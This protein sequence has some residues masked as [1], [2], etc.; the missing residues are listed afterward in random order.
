[1][2]RPAP[3]ATSL[4]LPYPTQ[5]SIPAYPPAGHR[6]PFLPSRKD[7]SKPVAP[8][9]AHQLPYHSKNICAMKIKLT[10]FL[11]ILK[12]TV[13]GQLDLNKLQPVDEH[14]IRCFVNARC[15]THG[16]STFTVE[17][18]P[19]FF[20][21]QFISFRIYYAEHIGKPVYFIQQGYCRGFSITCP[22]PRPGFY[23]V[24]FFHGAKP[25]FVEIDARK[26]TVHVKMYGAC[27]LHE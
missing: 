16:D 17:K 3:R 19:S 27:V 13:F 8:I 5:P 20:R 26:P 10:L 21:T 23:F 18:F 7:L 24:R 11:L 9:T 2:V 1:M 14:V 12:T 4:A 15:S 25:A 6:P 22:L